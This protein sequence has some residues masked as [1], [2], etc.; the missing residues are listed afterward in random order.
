MAGK[1][2]NYNSSFGVNK[3]PGIFFN[4]LASG[5]V[6]FYMRVTLEGK[7]ANIKIG[8]KSEGVNITY[9]YNKKKEFDARQRNG[10]LPDSIS[11]KIV[12]KNNKNS[13]KF[14]EIADAFFSFKLE[15]EP[16]NAVNIKEQRRDYEIYHKD[17]LGGLATMQITP[18]MI[19]E[20]HKDISQIISPKTKRKL[21]QS[22]INAIMGI[23]RTIFNHA[24]KNNLIDHISPY[25]IELKNQTTSEKGF[26]SLSR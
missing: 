14:D 25:K 26:W 8:S 6:V 3:Y 4:N 2:K 13:L 18:E 5:D 16:N 23:V 24:I 19:N 21:S 11:K 17:K 15:K 1:L 10:E 12:A 20:H 22:R 7:K 9:A